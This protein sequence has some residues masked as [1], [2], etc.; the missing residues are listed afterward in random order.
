MFKLKDVQKL[1]VPLICSNLAK[2]ENVKFK[3]PVRKFHQNT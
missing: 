3:S 2:V 1:C